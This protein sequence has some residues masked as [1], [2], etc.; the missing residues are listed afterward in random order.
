MLLVAAVFN[1]TGKVGLDAFAP[2]KSSSAERQSFG[3][4]GSFAAS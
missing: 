4:L 1:D 3:S 2:S